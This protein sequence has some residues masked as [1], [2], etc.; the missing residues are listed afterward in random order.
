MSAPLHLSVNP[1]KYRGETAPA[2]T[3][4]MESVIDYRAQAFSES[5]FSGSDVDS[6]ADTPT[7]EVFP[8]LSTS[9][10]SPTVDDR[11]LDKSM[12]EDFAKAANQLQR[13]FEGLAGS[14]MGMMELLEQ[15]RKMMQGMA[16]FG[17][18]L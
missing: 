6:G 12:I 15:G 11:R 3:D 7:I 17:N 5:E 8:P 18:K 16:E 9:G 4:D 10:I 13:D 2:H 14:M 1:S